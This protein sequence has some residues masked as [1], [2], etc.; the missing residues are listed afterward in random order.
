VLA[1]DQTVRWFSVGGEVHTTDGGTRLMGHVQDITSKKQVELALMESEERLRLALEAAE[2]GIWDWDIPNNHIAR[3][4]GVTALYGRSPGSLSKFDSFQEAIFPE[5]RERVSQ[6]IQSAVQHDTPYDIEFRVVWPN[7]EIHWIGSTGRVW[8][9]KCGTP[10]RMMGYMVDITKRKASEAAMRA[11]LEKAEEANKVKTAIFANMSHEIRTPMTAILGY[12]DLLAKRLAGSNLEKYAQTIYRGGT[13]L[14]HLLNSIVDL[15]RIESGKTAFNP[16]RFSANESIERVVNLLRVLAEQKGLQIAVCVQ[17][18]LWLETDVNA[19]EQVLTNI[20]GNA[21]R[22]TK[23]GT[24]TIDAERESP[25]ALRIRVTDTGIG[26]SSGFLAQV[27]DEFRQE[28]EGYGRTHE[29]SGLGLSISKKLIERMG[30]QIAIQSE[31][32]RGTTV[33]IVLPLDLAQSGHDIVHEARREEFPQPSRSAILIVEDDEA[34][35]DL[36][37]YFLGEE[38]TSW[39]KTGEEALRLAEER[40]FDL[41]LI[42]IHLKNSAFDGIET[43]RRLRG[44]LRNKQAP[45]IAL[46]A[47]AMTGDREA[48]LAKGFHDYLAKPFLQADLLAVV[49]KHLARVG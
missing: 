20:I 27:F 6:A 21:I 12:S 7:G 19:F 40:N 29:G 25:A 41:V 10:Y 11:A 33:S 18:A 13:R 30:G 43:L 31:K 16:V 46:T 37:R 42:D 28:S 17:D 15:A 5:D 45:A 4:G 26:I 34:T 49:Q 48:F 47:Y 1:A 35:G 3:T 32:G 44:V 36:L 22:F 14:L 23:E 24:V 38:N 9:K 2:I 39:C 8:R